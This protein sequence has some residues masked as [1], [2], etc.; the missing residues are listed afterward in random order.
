MRVDYNECE[1]G[2]HPSYILVALSVAIPSIPHCPM[3]IRMVVMA[4]IPSIPY[5]PMLV[6]IVVMAAIPKAL[7]IPSSSG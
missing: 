6:G 2:N 4:A 5:C 7:A 3:S 1:E